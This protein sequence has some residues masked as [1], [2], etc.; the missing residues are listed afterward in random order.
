MLGHLYN[1]LSTREN[2]V[3][4]LAYGGSLCFDVL[5]EGVCYVIVEIESLVAETLAIYQLIATLHNCLE[6]F[7][8]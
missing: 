1:N 8:N 6:Y 2:C 4:S 7:Q 5:Q 3:A